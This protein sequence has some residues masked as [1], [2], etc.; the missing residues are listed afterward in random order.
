MPELILASASPRRRE[1][2]HQI[3]VRFRCAPVDI[4]ETPQTGECPQAYVERLALGKAQACQAQHPGAVVLGSDTSV[5]VDAQILGKP[6]DEADAVRMLMQLSGRR[7]Q[8]MTAVALV[9]AG[10]QEVE[11]VVTQVDFAEL[12]EARCRAYWQTGEPC[13]KAGAYGIQGLGAVLVTSIEGS[14]SAVVGL[15][16]QQTAALLQ[17]FD[18]PVWEQV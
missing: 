1:L 17:A 18:I 16:L 5:V 14:Y 4:D 2:L 7:H 13:D 9:K 12:D 8:V 10:R 6:I 15:P 3:G 11:T